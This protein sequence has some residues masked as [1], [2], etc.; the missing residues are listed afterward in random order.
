L[1]AIDLSGAR[2]RHAAATPGPWRWAGYTNGRKPDVRLETVL[3]CGQ[4]VM[5]FAR[6]GFAAAQPTFAVYRNEGWP[7]VAGEPGFGQLWSLHELAEAERKAYPPTLAAVGPSYD[8]TPEGSERF[9]YRFDF[10]GIRHP[11][12]AFLEH[13]W[14]DM[15][16]ALAEID[17][18]RAALETA[19]EAF[20]ALGTAYMTVT[21]RDRTTRAYIVVRDA[22]GG[23]AL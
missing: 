9:Y 13:S 16:D 19:K 5:G 23:G 7:G 14:A 2:A 1:N 18:L 17:R 10:H 4:V 6:W 11:D 8:V 21:Q 3:G 22:L 20:V 15:R 12:A